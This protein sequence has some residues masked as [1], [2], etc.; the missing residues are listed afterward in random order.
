VNEGIGVGLA[1]QF[2][3]LQ[4]QG[5]VLRQDPDIPLHQSFRLQA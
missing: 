4:Q 5:R 1:E 2:L 3:E